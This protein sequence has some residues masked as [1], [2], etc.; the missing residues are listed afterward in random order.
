M[1]YV[2]DMSWCLE[3]YGWTECH[4]EGDAFGPFYCALLRKGDAT[5]M[6]V[7]RVA[8]V[9]VGDTQSVVVGLPGRVGW[10][11]DV[12]CGVEEV[13]GNA[14]PKPRNPMIKPRPCDIFYTY[15]GATWDADTWGGLGTG[16]H[17]TMIRLVVRGSGEIRE[18]PKKEVRRTFAHADAWERFNIAVGGPGALDPNF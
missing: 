10:V 16:D 4:G 8:I 17:P 18:I 2:D 7:D 13:A 15:N 11:F 9:M 1:S 5:V 3:S 12:V 14:R 6:V